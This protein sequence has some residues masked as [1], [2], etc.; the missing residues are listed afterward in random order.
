[1]CFS[2]Q[3]DLVGGVVISAVGVDAVRHLRQR[4]D[5]RLLAVLPLILGAHQIIEAFVW[6]GQEGRVPAALGVA[7]L[8]LYLLIALVLLP[9]FVPFAVRALEPPGHLR[10]RMVVFVAIGAGVSAILLWAMV[11]G[12][13]GVHVRPY[14]LAYSLPLKSTM[15]VVF[16]YVVAVCGALL[17]SG[18]RGVVV[19]GAVNLVAV[20]VIAV[21]TVDG[22]ASVWCGWAAV[23]SAAIASHVR[24]ARVV[25]SRSRLDR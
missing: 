5:H 18:Y 1:V 20:A 21:L 23:T 12:P 6:W 9:V 8:W 2:P 11:R 19:F 16:L 17:L 25:P 4:R 24:F 15:P 10:R 22:F 7:A 3:A 13:I 14:H